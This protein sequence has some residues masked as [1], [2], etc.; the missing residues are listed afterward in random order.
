MLIFARFQGDMMPEPPTLKNQARGR[1]E[2]A[3]IFAQ[4]PPRLLGEDSVTPG[5][6]VRARRRWQQF[7]SHLAMPIDLEKVFV[8]SAAKEFVFPR[9]QRRSDPKTGIKFGL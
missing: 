5:R 8:Y 6:P 1:R 3:N 7:A 2:L 4:K 9:G